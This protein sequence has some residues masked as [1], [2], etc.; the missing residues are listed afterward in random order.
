MFSSDVAQISARVD[1]SDLIAAPN[2]STFQLSAVKLASSEYVLLF[3]YDG[4]DPMRI[5]L[6][7]LDP[8]LRV[9]NAYSLTEIM[10]TVPIDG[11]APKGDAAVALSA[12]IIVGNVELAPGALGLDIVGKPG[13]QLFGRAIRGPAPGGLLWT[14]FSTDG[15][16]SLSYDQYD[17]A[18][19]RTS[20][21]KSVGRPYQL[22]G[23]FTDPEDP[24]GNSALL[25]FG[26]GS[27]TTYFVQ[28]PKDPDLSVSGGWPST[29]LF[30][31]QTFVSF[32]RSDLDTGSIAVTKTGIVAYDHRS[33]GWVRFLPTSPETVIGLPAA[34]R[35]G[36]LR[37]AFSYAGGYFCMYDPV[38]RVLTRYEDWW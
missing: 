25:V 12:S 18:W 34:N 1:L 27:N 38:S 28:V 8:S 14:N 29:A 5:H 32:A 17:A 16:G 2:A 9:L 15:M 11:W 30:D 35:S 22:H 36:E 3:S 33:Q 23:V 31:T 19:V 21:T 6:F 24:A 26:D 37:S 20:V 13:G 7:V 10:D 4:F